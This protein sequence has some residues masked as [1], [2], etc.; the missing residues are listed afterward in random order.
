MKKL[1]FLILSVAI[2]LGSCRFI[3]RHRVKGSG[4]MKTDE[5]SLGAFTGVRSYGSFD[6]YVSS[7]PQSVK[8]EAED[9]LLPYIETT[10]EDNTLK[11][12]TKDGA[13]LSPRNDIKIYVS[14]PAYTMVRSY[15]SGDIHGQS[16]ISG[17]SDLDL[18]II[19][20]A[21]IQLEADAPS[22]K[23]EVSG[24]GDLDLKGQT[25]AFKTSINGS[26]NVR[27][28][29]LKSEETEVRIAGSG[30]ADVFA[31][32]KLDV[33]VG[34]SGNVRYKGGAQVNSSMAGSGS[35]KKVD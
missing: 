17:N 15:G 11:V 19:G 26:G 27:A 35:V 30:D 29:D 5:R 1:S 9:N 13:W 33:H 8:I 31:S 18:G 34:G 24:S 10:V 22:I 28:F 25:K 4:N 12:T 14:L 32:T 7:G 16:K 2:L 20:S 3:D 23:A 6:V 21:N